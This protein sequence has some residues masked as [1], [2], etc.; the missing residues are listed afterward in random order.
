MAIQ[1]GT[2]RTT[3][4]KW[5]ADSWRKGWRDPIQAPL[6]FFERSERCRK[7]CMG[8]F[9]FGECRPDFCWL[10]GWLAGRLPGWGMF[11]HSSVLT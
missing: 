4:A 6:V 11:I 10:V 3:Q 1:R 9:P 2:L 5:T 7:W 8:Y